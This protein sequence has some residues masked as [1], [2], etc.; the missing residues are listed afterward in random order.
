MS[1]IF[2]LVIITILI[3]VIIR[4][5]NKLKKLLEKK[6]KLESLYRRYKIKYY[7][8]FKKHNGEDEEET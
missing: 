8:L 1:N 3:I 4:L 6:S 2:L 5:N 7:R